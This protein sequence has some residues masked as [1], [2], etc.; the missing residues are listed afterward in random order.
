VKGAVKDHKLTVLVPAYN[1]ED[2]LPILV[3]R[4]QGLRKGGVVEG[5]I[6]IVDDGSTDRTGEIAEELARKDSL[7]EVVRHRRNLGKSA[8]LRTGIP[9]CDGEYIVIMDADLQYAPEDIPRLVS[10]LDGGLDVVN[11]WRKNRKDPWVRKFPSAIYNLVSQI[12]FGLKIHDY[13]SGLKAFRHEVLERI[14]FRSD[15][16]R[17]VL[18][19]AHQMGFRVGEVEIRHFPREYGRTKYGSPVRFIL[20][21]LDLISLG[22]QLAFLE[23]PMTLFG[24]TGIL[25]SFLGGVFGLYVICLKILYREPF[26]HH[27]ALIQL[28]ALLVLTGLQSFFFGFLADI[29]ATTRIELLEHMEQMGRDTESQSAPRRARLKKRSR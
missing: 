18:P 8:A 15:L 19:L 16:H 10:A 6:L 24:L 12:V 1:E 4:L 14:S 25:L 27:V 23:R 3:G 17:Y 28:S 7:V 29:L 13:N 5:D 2:S 21:L 20:G 22:L 11:G 9:R 26:G